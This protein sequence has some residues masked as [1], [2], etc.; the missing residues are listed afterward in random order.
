MPIVKK[1]LR[2]EHDLGV[3][4][5]Y[6]AADNPDAAERCLRQIDS[7]F[8]KLAQSPFI[9]CERGDLAAHLRSLP[10]GNYVMF[11]QPAA[12]RAGVEIVCVI[13]GHRDIKRE[14]FE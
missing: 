12:T 6:I 14:M 2:V 7:Q 11:Y 3:I 8:H 5:D 4:W 10:A 9:G 1:A 13:Q